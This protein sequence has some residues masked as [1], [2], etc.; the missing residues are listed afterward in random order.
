MGTLYPV[1]CSVENSTTDFA[2]YTLPHSLSLLTPPTS[3]RWSTAQPCLHAVLA[4]AKSWRV[5][6]PPQYYSLYHC[7]QMARK[8]LGFRV[9]GSETLDPATGPHVSK[10]FR[11]SPALPLRRITNITAN[12]Q[13]F[14]LLSDRLIRV[15]HLRA[16]APLSDALPAESGSIPLYLE[17]SHV[18]I[19]SDRSDIGT[20]R[21]TERGQSSFVRSIDRSPHASAHNSRVPLENSPY[22]VPL[23]L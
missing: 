19:H 20:E 12:H 11:L 1:V 3:P 21:S 9:N 2:G 18:S 22:T 16:S 6:T 7:H 8:N 14:Q 5:L 15:P 4:D 10:L 23:L 13:I 17:L